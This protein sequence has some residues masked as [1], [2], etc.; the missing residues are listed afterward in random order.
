MHSTHGLFI[1]Y[2]LSHALLAIDACR[3]IAPKT[4]ARY[5]LGS[6]VK[7]QPT[8]PDERVSHQPI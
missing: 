7:K 1:V 6:I 4:F 2:L 3:W 5:G 8:N